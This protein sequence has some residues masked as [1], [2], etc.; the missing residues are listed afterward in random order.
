MS[1]SLEQIFFMPIE[2]FVDEAFAGVN[3]KISKTVLLRNLH[4]RNVRWVG[5]LLALKP[6]EIEFIPQSPKRAMLGLRLMQEHMKACGLKPESLV[7]VRKR[8]GFSVIGKSIFTQGRSSGKSKKIDVFPVD[9]SM[10]Y[11]SLFKVVQEERPRIAV[12]SLP[13]SLLKFDI[14]LAPALKEAYKEA[15]RRQITKRLNVSEV[16]V[17]AVNAA[18]YQAKKRVQ[19]LAPVSDMAMAI[20]VVTLSLD[21]ADRARLARTYNEKALQRLMDEVS[22]KIQPVAQEEIEKIVD[23]IEAEPVAK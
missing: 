1:G 11:A 3:K 20:A 12:L 5:Q 16:L 18:F 15:T 9:E 7:N 2:E 4:T 13:K 22:L 23:T 17:D 10:A 6:D 14:T 21:D 8:L 19:D